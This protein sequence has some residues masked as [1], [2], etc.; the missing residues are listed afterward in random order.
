MLSV[1]PHAQPIL[2]R[3]TTGD[4][5]LG[6]GTRIR[7]RVTEA[8]YTAMMDQVVAA[9]NSA[10]DLDMRK[11]VLVCKGSFGPSSKEWLDLECLK[12]A[13]ETHRFSGDSKVGDLETVRPD[14]QVYAETARLLA[15]RR[16]G[17]G[18]AHPY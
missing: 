9:D 4:F 7:S 8:D 14:G 2:N 12:D 1:P 11:G 18:H 5:S 16:H 6:E 17:R 3:W 10:D 13:G 15:G